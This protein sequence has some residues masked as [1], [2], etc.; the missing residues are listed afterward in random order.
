[1][2][3]VRQKGRKKDMDITSPEGLKTRNALALGS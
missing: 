2:L 1:M 3:D